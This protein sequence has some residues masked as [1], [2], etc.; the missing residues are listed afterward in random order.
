MPQPYIQQSGFKKPSRR[1]LS[2]NQKW[3]INK[4]SQKSA[5]TNPSPKTNY[6]KRMDYL[7]VLQA[8]IPKC[9]KRTS[10]LLGLGSC[11]DYWA[12]YL[13]QASGKTWGL[14]I[15]SASSLR[16]LF[17][18]MSFDEC[19]DVVFDSRKERSPNFAAFDQVIRASRSTWD[20]QWSVTNCILVALPVDSRVTKRSMVQLGLDVLAHFFCTIDRFLRQRHLTRT[21]PH[22][23]TAHDLPQK[24]AEQ[25]QN[26]ENEQF[27]Y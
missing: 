14:K 1:L 10:Q 4:P 3:S 5:S 21:Q 19:F 23:V 13:S 11:C 20:R 24:G 6:G 18:L 16:D 2:E 25:I 22:T 15:W 8:W 12:W 17:Q 9:S 26:V 7:L 27:S